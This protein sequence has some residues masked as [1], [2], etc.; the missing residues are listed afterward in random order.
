MLVLGADS[1]DADES[2]MERLKGVASEAGVREAIE[3]VGSVAHHEL[4]YFYSAADVCVMPSYSESFGLVGLEA[5]ACGCPVVASDVSG[6]R[7]VARDGVTGFLVAGDDPADYADRIARL[8]DDPELARQ[9]GRRGQLLAQRFSWS[10]TADRLAE[11]F[12]SLAERK[13]A[14]TVNGG[15]VHS[16]VQAGMRHE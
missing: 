12:S 4:P 6:L 11:L 13:A 10:R 5:Q 1:R 7:S 9:M 15:H 3:F 14:S 8:L 16:R 2:E